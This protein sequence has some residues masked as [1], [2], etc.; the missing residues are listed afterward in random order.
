M[1][2]LRTTASSPWRLTGGGTALRWLESF[3]PRIAAHLHDLVQRLSTAGLQTMLTVHALLLLSACWLAFSR[4]RWA[5]TLAWLAVI[6]F[7]LIW[8][9]VNQQ[10]EGRILY[11]FSP[12]HG[13]TEADLT[14][15]VVI[16]AALAVR[17]VRW[18]GRTW[19]RWRQARISAGVPSVLQ[20]M[21]PK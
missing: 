21:W 8:F 4:H 10:W 6:G 5:T 12:T 20:T 1:V 14:V 16:A 7:S 2:G 11:N 19:I 17:G 13:L 3:V 18:V 9:G 15:P